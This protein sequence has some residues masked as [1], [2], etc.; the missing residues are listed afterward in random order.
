MILCL[1]E[2]DFQRFGARCERPLGHKG[3]HVWRG[4]GSMETIGKVGEQVFNEADVE[5]IW[6]KARKVVGPERKVKTS[7]RSVRPAPKRLTA[8]ETLRAMF[9]GGKVKK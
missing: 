6:A 3:V 8:A 1:C 4:S 9:P 7:K 2:V 5:V